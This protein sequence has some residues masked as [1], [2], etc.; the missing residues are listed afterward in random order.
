MSSFA[1][2]T[3]EQVTN[4]LPPKES[5]IL[6][7]TLNLVMANK[8]SLE[9]ELIIDRLNDAMTMSGTLV[10][11]GFFEETIKQIIEDN[12]PPCVIRTINDQVWKDAVDWLLKDENSEHDRVIA[13]YFKSPN[14]GA[15]VFIVE[16][17]EKFGNPSHTAPALLT[18]FVG[19]EREGFPNIQQGDSLGRNQDI[20][21]LV[22]GLKPR[23]ESRLV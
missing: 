12:R 21:D 18:Y 2:E 8:T 9:K 19:E 4:D 22:K 10:G 16:R 17:R 5:S 6:I 1:T 3:E 13:R 11:P 15:W 14:N 23:N 20:F 7:Q